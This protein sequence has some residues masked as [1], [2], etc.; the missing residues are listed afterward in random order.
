MSI[1]L[2]TAAWA[3][4]V[5]VILALSAAAPPALPGS[6][7]VPA[8]FTELAPGSAWGSSA[9]D[10]F[11]GAQIVALRLG[12][13]GAAPRT[14]TSGFHSAA[15]PDVS[16]DGRKILFAGKKTAAE[17]WQIYEMNADGSAAR[18]V[19]ELPYDCRQPIYQSKIF[20]LDDPGP[21]AQ[22]TFAAAGAG[23]LA[24][25]GASPAW[26]LYSVRFDGSGL[27]RLT[28][29]PSSD[30]DP[31]LNEDGRIL[32]SSTERHTLQ[33]GGSGRV[34]LM[35]INLDGTDVAVFSADEGRAV[36]RMA[37]ATPSR[38]VVFVE[39]DRPSPEGA[40]NL[41]SVDLR[42][43]LHSYQEL[44]KPGAALY[45][46]PAAW[47]ES[48]ILVSRRTA[49]SPYALV[50]FNLKTRQAAPLYSI[51]GRHLVQ[52]K[53]L[54]AHPMPDG[55]SSVVEETDLNGK[56]YCL[57]VFHTELKDPK[58]HDASVVKRVRVLEGVARKTGEAP[59][60]GEQSPLLDKRILGD[61]AV[62]ADGS[63]HV[64]L[65]ANIPIQV[66]TLDA[67]GQALRTS[68]WIWIKNK[69]N[70]GCAGC[71]EDNEV[72]PENVFA[73]ALEKPAVEL[74]LPPSQRRSRS[75]D[76]DVRPALESRCATGT[77]HQT[78][79]LDYESIYAKK[80]VEPGSAR[81]SKLMPSV[82]KATHRDVNPLTEAEYKA[83]V[84]WIDTGAHK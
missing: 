2:V 65:P 43:N 22:L 71:H 79:R 81:S 52:A 60:A 57:S 21:V 31:V 6:S 38:Q 67:R 42:R 49:S 41:A 24:E 72:S 51:P 10:P 70:R 53:R 58:E 62:E 78:D 59:R 17:P 18:R 68:A 7:G 1:R 27:R 82:E 84:E 45:Y 74:T 77:C 66:Q 30:V 9:K 80:L 48:D 28:Y 39:S 29:N 55:R 12:A 37:A 46:A 34:A 56:I 4:L 14:L 61:F 40:G 64:H 20:Y 15:D 8:V 73:T 76:R 16:W 32:Y 33:W 3:A 5:G 54:A 63:F 83:I 50:R 26:S 69:E 25:D 35:G 47:D 23:R 44:T 36:K 75:F 19:I 11:L 13:A